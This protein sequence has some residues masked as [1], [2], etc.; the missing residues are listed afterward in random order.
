MAFQADDIADL[1]LDSEH[2]M[3][4]TLKTLAAGI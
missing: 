2:G 3:G 4:Y 1:E